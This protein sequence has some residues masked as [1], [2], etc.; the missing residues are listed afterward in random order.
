MVTNWRKNCCCCC[1]APYPWA[2][3]PP[4]WPPPPP[5]FPEFATSKKT[6]SDVSSDSEHNF[7]AVVPPLPM[8]TS[9]IAPGSV[10]LSNGAHGP[11]HPAVFTSLDVMTSNTPPAETPNASSFPVANIREKDVL[12][13]TLAKLSASTTIPPVLSTHTFIS[14]NPTWSK[15]HAKTSKQ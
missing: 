4:S 6:A 7:H 14:S 1:C 13:T 3:Y 8:L 15:E 12:K 9:A 5:S 2:P 10:F 11:T